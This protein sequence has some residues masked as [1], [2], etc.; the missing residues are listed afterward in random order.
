MFQSFDFLLQKAPIFFLAAARAFGMILT[1]PLISTRAV[2]RTAKVAL[3][4]FIAFLVMPD[5]YPNAMDVEAFSLYYAL[6]VLGEGLIGVLTGFYIVIIF[7]VFSTAG[8]FFTYQ[9]GFGA[10][11]V[12]DSLAQVE[13]PLMGQYFNFIAAIVF[14]RIHG[15]HKLFFTGVFESF[16]T[17]NCFIFLEKQEP[18]VNVLIKS[19]GLLFLKAMV[20]SLPIIG[21]LILIHVTMGLLTKAAPQMNLLSEGFPITILVTFFLLTVML[22]YLIN[23]FIAILEDGFADFRKL[24][25]ELGGGI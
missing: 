25:I 15:F 2:P 7:S 6:L 12:Y 11:G 17:I 8:Q 24:L 16:E 4:G 13:N 22:P 21:T 9:M 20:M 10:S 1:T 23:S 14:L 18:V 19:V 5:A 3:A